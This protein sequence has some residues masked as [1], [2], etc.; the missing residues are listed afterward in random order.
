VTSKRRDYLRYQGGEGGCSS[1]TKR[2]NAIK[3]KRRTP[4][5]DILEG[6][7]ELDGRTEKRYSKRY[8]DKQKKSTTL[9]SRR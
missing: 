9:Q 4:D 2:K 8:L 3:V 1:C 5:K 7:R 6:L